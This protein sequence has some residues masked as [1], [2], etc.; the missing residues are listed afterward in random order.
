M[1][2][3]WE[4][5][6]LFEILSDKYAQEILLATSLEKMSAKELIER[7]DASRATVYRRI[8][9]LIEQDLLKEE[10]KLDPQGNHY[11]IYEINLD[12]IEIDVDEGRFDVEITLHEDVADR[13][14]RLW[15]GIRNQ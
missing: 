4:L 6:E 9:M 8:D 7:C 5:D 11:K 2:E 12:H 3:D 13:F 15:E 10:M 14:T 1:R